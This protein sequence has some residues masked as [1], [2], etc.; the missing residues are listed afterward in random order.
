M[1]ELIRELKELLVRH[2]VRVD[3]LP[4]GLLNGPLDGDLFFHL[5]LIRL[6][7]HHL[8]DKVL[9]TASMTL[10]P[11]FLLLLQLHGYLKRE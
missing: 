11:L 3:C 9:L 7:H 10:S 4:L 2:H 5:L 1:A 6:L 8:A